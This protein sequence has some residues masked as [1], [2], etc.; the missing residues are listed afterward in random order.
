MN[1]TDAHVFASGVGAETLPALRLSVVAG[2]HRA[3]SDQASV[4]TRS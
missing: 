2:T 1:P 3:I 4:R